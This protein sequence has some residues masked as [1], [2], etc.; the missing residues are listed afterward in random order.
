[1]LKQQNLRLLQVIIKK[2]NNESHIFREFAGEGWSTR[3]GAGC[4]LKRYSCLQSSLEDIL[5]S[6]KQIHQSVNSRRGVKDTL[7][8]A[9][10]GNGERH[11]E[12]TIYS[13]SEASPMYLLYLAFCKFV[14]I[15]SRRK[16]CSA[17]FK[18]IDM[19]NSMRHIMH[20]R[21]PNFQATELYDVGFIEEIHCA[22]YRV[23]NSTSREQAGYSHLIMINKE[24]C[25]AFM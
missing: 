16:C 12:A 3:R 23:F 8:A 21:M 2:K 24:S 6:S 5:I 13:S 25:P 11:A 19:L 15:A 10:L 22:V 17:A 9:L 1:M 7:A 14:E 4:I 18:T 20:Q